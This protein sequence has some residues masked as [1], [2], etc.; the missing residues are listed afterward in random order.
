MGRIWIGWASVAVLALVSTAR[1]GDPSEALS[2]L[3]GENVLKHIKVLASDAFEGRGPGTP[4]EDKTVAYLIEQFKGSA[5][6]P[7][8]P[9]G[10]TSRRSRWSASRPWRPRGRS[11]FKD[12]T[13][14]L[15]SRRR[16]GRRLPQVRRARWT[17]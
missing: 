15:K 2:A 13:I 14:D 4:G 5:S 12:K 1:A 16:L 17:S 10:P 9:T 11:E 8:T 3:S 6:S 7:A